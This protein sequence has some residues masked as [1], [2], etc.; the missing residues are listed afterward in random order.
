MFEDAKAL[1]KAEIIPSLYILAYIKRIKKEIDIPD[2]DW[3]DF[4][5]MCENNTFL[6]LFPQAKD[7]KLQFL[8]MILNQAFSRKDKICDFDDTKHP[9]KIISICQNESHSEYSTTE[10]EQELTIVLGTDEDS[11]KL[12]DSDPSYWCKDCC[13]SS[14]WEGDFGCDMELGH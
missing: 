5:M 11:Q 12:D 13:E 6:E 1:E 14:E 7:S 4:E 9:S 10:G 2:L 8:R 3:E